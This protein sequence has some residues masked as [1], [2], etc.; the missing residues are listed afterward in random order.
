[1]KIPEVSYGINN[2]KALKWLVWEENMSNPILWWTAFK[3]V[4]DVENIIFSFGLLATCDQFL[5]PLCFPSDQN[6]NLR[7]LRRLHTA[8]RAINCIVSID[9]PQESSFCVV[10]STSSFFGSCTSCFL[11]RCWAV[12]WLW[13]TVLLRNWRGLCWSKR[14]LGEGVVIRED[15]LL[16]TTSVRSGCGENVLVGVEISMKELDGK[17]G[18]TVCVA[19]KRSLGETLKEQQCWRINLGS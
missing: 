5:G 2:K 10:S 15:A 4:G 13:L 1:M 3:Q 7:R 11:R 17:K 19:V 8:L 18:M 6:R 14:R 9:W 12:A 16:T